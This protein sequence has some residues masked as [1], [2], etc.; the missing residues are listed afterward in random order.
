MPRTLGVRLGGTLALI[1]ILAAVSTGSLITWFASTNILMAQQNLALAEFTRDVQGIKS[2]ATVSGEPWNALEVLDGL[3]SSVPSS[4]L[5]VGRMGIVLPSL[6]QASGGTLDPRQL[7]ATF[8]ERVEHNA[9]T[10]PD[11]SRETVAGQS[12]FVVGTR[13]VV[14]LVRAG[15]EVGTVDA[16]VYA[17]YPF[18][19]Q[20]DQIRALSST[21]IVLS[22]MIGVAGAA[23]GWLLA[24]QLTRPVL[25]LRRAI[26]QF[27]AGVEPATLPANTVDE[28]DGVI[29]SFN[30]MSEQLHRS[31]SELK[32]SEERARRFVADVSHELRTP[33]A[34]MVALADVL[35][36]AEAPGPLRA[37]AGTLISSSARR[38]ANLTE[39][40]LEISRFDS[41]SIVISKDVFDVKMRLRDLVE[42]RFPGSGIE[43]HS[44]AGLLLETDPRRFDLVVSNLVANALRHGLPPIVVDACPMGPELRVSV[45]DHGDGIPAADVEKVFYRFFKSDSS[46]SGDGTGLGLSL[47]LENIKAL[48]GRVE[49]ATSPGETTFCATLPR[50]VQID[51]AER[52]STISP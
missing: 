7:P 2:K 45:T 20:D 46:R 3:V 12:V 9:R 50:L 28:L 43:V 38:L 8:R 22:S 5:D 49:I 25:E 19:A 21:S 42:A 11:F 15:S 41:H 6:G 51:E 31:V 1:A 26:E 17:V 18:S 47:V 39:D 40:L 37:E 14:T 16:F 24:R 34:A 52:A 27:D 35:G 30:E 32:D 44:P 29:T 4:S 33:T 36:H 10:A 13:K 23:V 48:D